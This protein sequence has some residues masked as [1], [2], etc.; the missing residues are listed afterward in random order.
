MNL[1]QD[2]AKFCRNFA[3]EYSN[4]NKILFYSNSGNIKEFMIQH[5]M[6]AK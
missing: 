3:F 4:K 6:E 5:G 2:D 1:H